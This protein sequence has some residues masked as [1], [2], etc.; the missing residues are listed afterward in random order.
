[1]EPW[2]LLNGTG[3]NV[4]INPV[5]PTAETVDRETVVLYP[6]LIRKRKVLA[7]LRPSERLFR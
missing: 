7:R 4:N 2:V 1:M 5:R 6:Q 3:E